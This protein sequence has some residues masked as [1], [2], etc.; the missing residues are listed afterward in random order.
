MPKCLMLAKWF[1]LSDPQMEEQVND[2]ISFRRF[3]GL[4][5]DEQAPDE[6]TM[7]TFRD[8]LRAARL[9]ERLFETMNTHLEQLGLFVREGSIVDASI[10]E[11]SR[12]RKNDHGTISR[13]AEAS[14]TKKSGQ[15][16]HGYKLHT[17]VDAGSGL[18]SKLAFTTAKAHDSTQ[19][20]A[21]TEEEEAAVIADSAYADQ[22]RRRRLQERGV[23]DGLAYKRV[24]GQGRLRPWQERFNRVVAALRGPGEM[25]FAWLK[26]LQG[27]VRVRYRGL[28]RNRDDA[29]MHALAFNARRS[30]S[31][32]G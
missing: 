15:I 8:R 12:P 27:F 2:R 21:L 3:V 26:R 11:Q 1:G 14:Y 7:V 18:I 25:P 6:T 19:I 23:M 24:R 22:A 17:A 28:Q 5:G 20:D 13:D 32:S 4:R 9:F 16:R 31:L 10:I 29:L 30:L